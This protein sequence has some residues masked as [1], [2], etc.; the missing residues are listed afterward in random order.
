MA[1]RLYTL[2]IEYNDEVIDQD[3]INTLLDDFLGTIMGEYGAVPYVDDTEKPG[4]SKIRIAI[5][6]DGDDYRVPSP[7]GREEGAYY[8]GDIQD[9]IDTG[10]MFYKGMALD[11]DFVINEVHEHPQ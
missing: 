7:D 8:T 9:A 3:G 1:T 4:P 6:Y 2:K 11:L 5:T 10:R